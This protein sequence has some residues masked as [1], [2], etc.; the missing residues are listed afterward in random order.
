MEIKD[1]LVDGPTKKVYSTNQS[2]QVIV[3]YND[4]TGKGKKKDGGEIAEMNNTVTSYLFEYLESYNVPTHFAKKLDSKSFLAKK[5]DSISMV[6]DVYNVASK[7][8]AERLSIDEGTV[9]EYPIVELYY[10]DE[11]NT[12]P[13]INEYHAYALGLC[14]RKDMTSIMRIATKVNAVF[15]SFFDRKKLK[16]VN[17][18]LEFGRIHN[19]IVLADE[20]SLDTLNLWFVKEDG[21]FDRVP[22]GSDKSKDEYQQ[23]KARIFGE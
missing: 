7:K 20:V 23:L 12:R 3:A 15:K 18:S 21:S 19:Q 1:L 8:L 6:V 16:L 11:K 13:M 9:L 2:D 17:F 14:E 5:S 22:E 10:K 4:S